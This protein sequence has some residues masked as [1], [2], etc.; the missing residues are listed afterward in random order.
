MYPGVE[1][2]EQINCLHTLVAIHVLEI[3]CTSL[4]RGPN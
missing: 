2:S 3:E 1:S 4:F